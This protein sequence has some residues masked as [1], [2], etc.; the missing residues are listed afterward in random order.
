MTKLCCPYCGNEPP[1]PTGKQPF[2]CARCKRVV[3]PAESAASPEAPPQA[4]GAISQAPLANEDAPPPEPPLKYMVLEEETSCGPDAN[5]LEEAFWREDTHEAAQDVPIISPELAAS[6]TSDGLD[7]GLPTVDDTLGGGEFSFLGGAEDEAQESDGE[8]SPLTAPVFESDEAGPA[9][10]DALES[11]LQDVKAP[12]EMT[13][14]EEAAAL[15]P[16]V[17]LPGPPEPAKETE[18]HDDAVA[19]GALEPPTFSDFA[20]YADQV[21][22]ALAEVQASLSELEGMTQNIESERAV[23]REDL[24]IMREELDAL[25]NRTALAGQ[26]QALTETAQ[27]ASPM[28]E[29]P[30]AQSADELD[31]GLS[32]MIESFMRFTGRD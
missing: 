18:S 13:D 22:K 21:E 30:Q 9:P 5:P 23:L 17:A 32:A 2:W 31:P 16:L 27:A 15:E 11:S 14:G 28:E 20:A 24:R 4:D 6:E 12:F 3:S 25:P 1:A 10:L 8:E 7:E 29:P 19:P 26:K